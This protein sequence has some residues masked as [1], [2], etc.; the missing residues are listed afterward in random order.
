MLL[1][2]IQMFNCRNNNLSAH[3]TSLTVYD[4]QGQIIGESRKTRKYRFSGISPR[5]EIAPRNELLSIV[6]YGVIPDVSFAAIL[7][8][9]APLP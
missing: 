7:M 2:E 4:V 5:G 3:S 6:V 8:P 1:N 9:P